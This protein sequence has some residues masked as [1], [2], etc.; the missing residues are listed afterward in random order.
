M[1]AGGTGMQVVVRE[2]I[3]TKIVPASVQHMRSLKDIKADGTREVF[4]HR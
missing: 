3:G 1:A 4:V 2:A